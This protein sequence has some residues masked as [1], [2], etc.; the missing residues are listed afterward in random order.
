VAK[1]SETFTGHLTKASKHPRADLTKAVIPKAVLQSTPASIEVG[2]ASKHTGKVHREYRSHGKR[3]TGTSM[4]GGGC[5]SIRT[6]IDGGRRLMPMPHE[7]NH[8][9][10]FLGPALDPMEKTCSSKLIT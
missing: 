3:W 7:V 10:F 5:T 4:D 9:C 6:A 8:G 1:R 2:G